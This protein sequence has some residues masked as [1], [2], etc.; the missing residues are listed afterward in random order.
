MGAFYTCHG[1]RCFGRLWLVFTQQEKERRRGGQ[2]A[3]F[4]AAGWR[5]RA[6]HHL[7]ESAHI[8]IGAR[9]KNCY[10]PEANNVIVELKSVDTLTAVHT[11]QVITY[12]KLSSI[13]VGL[14][15]NFNVPLLNQGVRR[16]VRPDLYIRK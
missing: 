14:L 5:P 4:G 15:M 3:A 10:L 9:F 11:A 6:N 12:L 7:A 1:S 8:S 13:P 16:L 2:T